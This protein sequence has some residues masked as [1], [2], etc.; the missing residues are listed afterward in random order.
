MA[1]ATSTEPADLRRYAVL[2]QYF[3]LR[4]KDSQIL[5][6]VKDPVLADH[7]STSLE[8]NARSVKCIEECRGEILASYQKLIEITEK[9]QVTLSGL[10]GRKDTVGWVQRA[11]SFVEQ[12]STPAGLG[13]LIFGASNPIA[14]V[15]GVAFTRFFAGNMQKKFGEI[16]QNTQI[17]SPFHAKTHLPEPGE[18][19]LILSFSDQP[20]YKALKEQAEEVKKSASKM[21]V[22]NDPQAI[23]KVEHGLAFDHLVRV[24]DHN[25][26]SRLKLVEISRAFSIAIEKAEKEYMELGQEAKKLG[27]LEVLWIP[28]EATPS[29][30]RQI[31]EALQE[32]GQMN[33]NAFAR[34]FWGDSH[35]DETGGSSATDSKKDDDGDG[36]PPASKRAK[37]EGADV[38]KKD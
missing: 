28:I 1:G 25:E 36:A 19:D 10:H 38:D 34:A 37:S 4:D 13:I 20:W 8:T 35:K 31:M 23:R 9:I 2:F 6:E 27:L 16:L 24:L 26:T 3:E 29:A 18:T 5:D 12:F 30:L 14:A 32:G 7:I 33:V 21:D 22:E 11:S 17:H 15:A